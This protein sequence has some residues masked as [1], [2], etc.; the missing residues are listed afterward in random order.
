[1]L[2]LF[3]MESIPAETRLIYQITAVSIRKNNECH[4]EISE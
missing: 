4:D 1:M 3:R 2:H